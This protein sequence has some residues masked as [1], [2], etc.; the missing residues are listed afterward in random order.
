[1]HVHSSARSNAATME[2]GVHGTGA[3]N[4]PAAASRIQEYLKTYTETKLKL[5]RRKSSPNPV[6]DPYSFRWKQ[7]DD[8]G[9]AGG[10]KTYA[11]WAPKGWPD[12]QQDDHLI[13]RSAAGA[14][15]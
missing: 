6:N 5:I 13:S 11:S 15:T 10:F 7:E 14:C 9:T 12:Q 4:R 2:L 3:V 8:R 1:M